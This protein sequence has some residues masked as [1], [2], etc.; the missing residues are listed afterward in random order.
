VALGPTVA[1]KEADA[2]ISIA[3]PIDGSG[4]NLAKPNSPDGEVHRALEGLCVLN[5]YWK[6]KPLHD[7][8]VATAQRFKEKDYV[9][10]NHA[11]YALKRNYAIW[12]PGN[13][14]ENVAEDERLLPKN[15]CYHRN[16]AFASAQI[17]SLLNLMEEIAHWHQ[18]AKT[19]L[20]SDTNEIVE[21]AIDILGRHYGGVK[22]AYMSW[23]VQ[24]QIESKRAVVDEVRKASG[25]VPLFKPD[26]A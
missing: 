4:V 20:S 19:T 11:V 16:L 1:R 26:S 9:A 3:T 12:F 18:Q 23:S 17:E 15:G 5:K 8:K 10:A 25:R 24:Q 13:F 14:A 6:D 7:W 2:P 21:H 22:E